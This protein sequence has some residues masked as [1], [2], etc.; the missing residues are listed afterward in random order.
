[1]F[2]TVGGQDTTQGQFEKNKY[3]FI[4]T[5]GEPSADYGLPISLVRCTSVNAEGTEATVQYQIGTA[6]DGE[7]RPW[8][9]AGVKGNRYYTESGVSYDAVLV[10]DVQRGQGAVFKGKPNYTK[11]FKLSHLTLR[12]L[13]ELEEARFHLFLVANRSEPEADLR[14][15]QAIARPADAAIGDE[16]ALSDA[17]T[18]TGTDSSSGSSSD[19]DTSAAS[20]LGSKCHSTTSEDCSSSSDEDDGVADSPASPQF[21]PTKRAKSNASKNKGVAQHVMTKHHDQRR[22][23]KDHVTRSLADTNYRGNPN[24]R[25]KRSRKQDASSAGQSGAKRAALANSLDL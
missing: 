18:D 6:Y 20:D 8:L 13:L 4:R 12:R 5:A 19:S 11:P 25:A 9:P 22:H 2:W 23:E 14:R 3:Y 1:L 21:L 24:P 10:T 16:V 17:G 7:W 15:A